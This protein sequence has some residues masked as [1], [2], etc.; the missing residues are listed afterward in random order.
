MCSR[1]PHLGIWAG[2]RD[3]WISWVEKQTRTQI[4]RKSRKTKFVPVL[5]ITSF[6]FQIQHACFLPP[7]IRDSLSERHLAHRCVTPSYWQ[8][9]T[10]HNDHNGSSWSCRQSWDDDNI[11]TKLNI[12][13][14]LAQKNKTLRKILQYTGQ[15]KLFTQKS[16]TLL[17]VSGLYNLFFKT[18][19]FIVHTDHYDIF[20]SM[21][22][23]Y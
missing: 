1:W 9:Y 15:H 22:F 16:I 20:F 8:V 6:S 10:D 11:I 14:I 5:T 12:F 23:T 17:N 19:M 4:L 3:E 7:C 18:T 2:S 21:L 13:L